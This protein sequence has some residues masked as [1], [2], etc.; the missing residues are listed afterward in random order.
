MS[1]PPPTQPPA[2]LS[3]YTANDLLSDFIAA[4]AH[5]ITVKHNMTIWDWAGDQYYVSVHAASSVTFGDASSCT[6]G[7]EPDNIGLWV[8]SDNTTANQAYDEVMNDTNQA[9]MTPP[10]GPSPGGLGAPIGEYIHARCLL[11]GGIDP[12]SIYVQVVTRDCV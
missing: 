11:L 10:S 3:V 12:E 4:G 2:P 1:T 7:C 8:Y 5:P 6:G 9:A